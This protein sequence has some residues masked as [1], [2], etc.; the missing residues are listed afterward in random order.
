MLLLLV[1][2]MESVQSLQAVVSISRREALAVIPVSTVLLSSGAR[3]ASVDALKEALREALPL[4]SKAP[5]TNVS[6][7]SSFEVEALALELE[8]L[9]GP[10]DVAKIEGNWRLLYSNAPEIVSLASLPFGFRL[11]QVDQP[12][13]LRKGTFENQGLLS[14]GIAIATTRVVGDFSQRT[15]A[16]FDVVFQRVIFDFDAPPLRATKVVAP[17]AEKTRFVTVTYVDDDFR[18]TRGGDGALFILERAKD[19]LRPMLNEEERIRLYSDVRADPVTAGAGLAN[20][21]KT[22][23]FRVASPTTSTA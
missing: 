1:F 5:W 21:T 16:V 20:W 10:L 6:L 3:A 13:D 4:K 22:T 7:A 18:I 17:K 8:T 11:E 12:F 23:L 14:N 9:A 2:V 19:R 15:E